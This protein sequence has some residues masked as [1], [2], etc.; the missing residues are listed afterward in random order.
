M[1]NQNQIHVIFISNRFPLCILLYVPP[2]ML[3]LTIVTPM[4]NETSENIA[5]SKSF[6]LKSIRRF[7]RIKTGKHMTK[8]LRDWITSIAVERGC[9]LKTS[10]TTSKIQK[11][12]KV[13]Y[14]LFRVVYSIHLTMMSPTGPNT[15]WY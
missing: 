7:H 4:V 2:K 3:P 9:L 15:H 13:S 11:F 5:E 10:D 14:V 8:G 1:K 6:F 12:L